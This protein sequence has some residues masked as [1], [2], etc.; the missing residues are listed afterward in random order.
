M[1]RLLFVF[2]GKVA[3]NHRFCIIC[4]GHVMSTEIT[5]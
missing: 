5:A 1:V 4:T 3:M 2:Y